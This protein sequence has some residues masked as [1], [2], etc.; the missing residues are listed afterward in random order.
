MRGAGNTLSH[1]TEDRRML[2]T[3]ALISSTEPLQLYLIPIS[4]RLQIFITL[5]FLITFDSFIP[6]FQ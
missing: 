4:K 1:V 2:E 5:G 6:S 3:V